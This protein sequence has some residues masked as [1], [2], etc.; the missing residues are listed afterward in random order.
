MFS[1]LVRRNSRRSRKENGLFFTSLVISIVAFYMILSLSKQDVMLFLQKM[2]SDAVHKLMLLIP[3]F[4]GM[5]LV[6]LFFLIYFA[7]QYQ[8]ERRRHEF[9]VYLM[10]GMRRGKLFG[11]LLAEDVYN[12]VLALLVG[13]PVAVLLSELVSLVTAKLVGMGIIGHRI[14][15]SGSAVLGTVAGFLAIKLLAFLILSGRISR[16]EIGD[17]LQDTPKGAKKQRPVWLHG[18][19]AV[20]GLC[21]LAAAYYTAI[22][23][24]AWER[25][26]NM[27][28]TLLFGLTGTFLLFYGMRAVVALLL[29]KGQSGRKLGVFNFRQVEETVIH[30]S[31]SMAI[32]SLLILAAL[33]CCGAG[34]GMAF[35]NGQQKAHVLDYT[36]DDF[37]TE[38]PEQ[39]FPKVQTI[40]QE[41]GLEDSFADLAPLRLGNI[42][43]TKEY[44]GVFVMDSVMNAIEQLPQSEETD[45]LLNNL[46]YT[47]K[48]HILCLSDY[49]HLLE[50]AGKPTLELKE[51]E[52]GIYIDPTFT[53][54]KRNAILN[55]ILADHPQ[56]ELDGSP[57][58]LTGEV[59][60]I[61]VVTDY[62]ITLSF[63][64]ILP[65]EQFYHYTQG[66]YSVYVNGVLDLEA[67]PG[68]SL[69]NAISATNEK[70]NAI[71]LSGAD[72]K[73][74]SYLQNIGR[75]L[76]FV[77]SSSYLTMYL[78]IIFLVVANTLL[79]VQFLM[80]QQR[81]GRRYETLI[82]L[83]ASYET[84]CRSAKT[85]INWHFM[86]PILVAA[87][88]SVFGVMALFHGMLPSATYGREPIMLLIAGA[89]ILL[90]CVVEYGYMTAV[91]RASDRYLLAR[92]QPR[93]EE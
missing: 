93:R 66:K 86:M 67:F 11:M 88:S 37:G 55:T 41:N 15:L 34:V 27:G 31:A 23:G 62:S 26:G 48:P 50:L 61:S 72:I 38:D 80:N 90:L 92:M 43:T 14:T 25:V 69:M 29:K 36:F 8:L 71:D 64:L 32:S 77:V 63:A 24:N 18:I 22:V 45:I 7:C 85:Q 12:S 49:N 58:Y 73:Y 53:D 4:Y 28:K 30:Q 17:L 9:G 46:S 79:G 33:C 6:I 82:R 76:F 19:A 57:I 16:R 3:A 51:N 60:T 81:A 70:L 13:L 83:G 89:M 21:L 2:E 44:E 56:A 20:V 74:E 84:L 68:D 5:S 47:D 59:Q 52:A 10:M 75:Q 65:D 35:G 78:A 1:D 87:F 91:K 54:E 40:L 39:F 42:R